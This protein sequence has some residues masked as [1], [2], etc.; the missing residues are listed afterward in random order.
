MRLNLGDFDLSRAF[1]LPVVF[2]DQFDLKPNTFMTVDDT[3]NTTHVKCSVSPVVKVVVRP[4][5]SGL[6]NGVRRLR[7]S[8]RSCIVAM[9][10]GNTSAW[11]HTA[12][13]AFHR[14]CCLA[15]DDILEVESFGFLST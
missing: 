8:A 9:Q 15:L 12:E 3:H 5:Q 2:V 7:F 1:T 14:V 10:S 4:K 6:G 11:T 13:D